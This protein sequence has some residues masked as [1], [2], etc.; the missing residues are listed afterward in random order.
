MLEVGSEDAVIASEV[1]A[2]T[3]YQ[4]SQ[5]CDERQRVDHDMGCSVAEGVLELM[6]DLTAV[7]DAGP[8]LASVS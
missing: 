4:R 3:G 7:I 8:L 1:G 6:D 5:A 2:R